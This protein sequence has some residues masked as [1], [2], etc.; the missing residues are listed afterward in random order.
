MPDPNAG[1]VAVAAGNDH[2]L[3]LKYDG[4]IVA[5]GHNYLGQCDV[6]DPNTGFVVAAA[7]GD[8]NLGLKCLWL[9][10]GA[11]CVGD[12]CIIATEAACIEAGGTYMGDGITCADA[13]CPEPCPADINGDG[14]VNIDDIFEIL[15]AWGP[16]E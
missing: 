15:A 11:C 1:F 2:S 4:S 5:W 3:G 16:C 12:A 9:P 14:K 6:P 7:G 10:T 13:D 8:H